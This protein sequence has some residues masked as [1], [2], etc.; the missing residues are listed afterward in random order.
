MSA[1][2]TVEVW[3][4]DEGWVHLHHPVT[5][6]TTRVANNREVVAGFLGRGWAYTPAPPPYV[7]EPDALPPVI[8]ITATGPLDQARETEVAAAGA[9][10][11]VVFQPFDPTDLT[12]AQVIDAVTA[13]PD[14][15]AAALTAERAGKNRT[16]LTSALEAL[17]AGTTTDQ[18]PGNG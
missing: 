4:D 14:L 17:A 8:T 7:A 16:S 6:G 5:F 10:A 11:T 9:T 12:V 13:N 2:E 3:I 18:E 15:A 1:P